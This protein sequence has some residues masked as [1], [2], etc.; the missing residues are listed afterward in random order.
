VDEEDMLGSVLEERMRDAEATI[1][2]STWMSQFGR[3]SGY[4]WFFVS[5]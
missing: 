4:K 2:I 1:V 5:F 3:G